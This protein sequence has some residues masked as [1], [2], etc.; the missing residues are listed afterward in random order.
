MCTKMKKIYMYIRYTY[1][2]FESSTSRLDTSLNDVIQQKK[3]PNIIP[4]FYKYS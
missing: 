1:I 4:V 2:H 3:K